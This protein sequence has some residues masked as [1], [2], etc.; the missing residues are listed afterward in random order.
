MLVD[1]V[2]GVTGVI[3]VVGVVATVVVAA[4]AVV[5][6]VAVPKSGGGTGLDVDW[7][8]TYVTTAPAPRRSAMTASTMTR[9][10]PPFFV[11]AR[12]GS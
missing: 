11:G 9:P 4:A 3:G 7:V 10:E 8:A 6:A 5:V 2:S 1:V 12:V